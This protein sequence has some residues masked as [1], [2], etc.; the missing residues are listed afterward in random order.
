LE[1]EMAHQ[2]VSAK[3]GLWMTAVALAFATPAMAQDKSGTTAPSASSAAQ[4]ASR[5]ASGATGAT[6]SMTIL[7]PMMILVPTKVNVDN[8][9]KNGCWVRLYDQK[10]FQ[11]DSFTLSGAMDLAE[12]KGPFGFNW[13]NKVRSL[14]IGPKASL[15][16]YDN[17][18]FRDQDRKIATGSKV[19]DLSKKMGFFDNFRSMKMTCAS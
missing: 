9:T 5:A 10:N 15:T 18:N 4:G 17:R 14:E 1:I 12:M 13:E 8:A 19:P 16:I 6:Q 2:F 7:T 11:G 3:A